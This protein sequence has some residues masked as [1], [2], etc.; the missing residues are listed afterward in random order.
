MLKPG[1]NP[2]IGHFIALK[3]AVHI[4]QIIPNPIRFSG[5]LNARVFENPTFQIYKF[6]RSESQVWDNHQWSGAIDV[7]ILNP[8]K[9]FFH[10]MDK[11]G[12]FSLPIHSTRKLLL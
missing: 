7:T 4:E 3:S 11:A 5:G 10:R 12:N 9:S 1:D 8:I 2:G 6:R